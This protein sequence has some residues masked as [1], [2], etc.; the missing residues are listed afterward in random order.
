MLR[1]NADLAN[2]VE[3][4]KRVGLFVD[5]SKAEVTKVAEKCKEVHVPSGTTIVEQGTKGDR[6]FVLA[7][8]LAHVHVDGKKVASI[9]PGSFFGEMALIEHE[10]RSATVTAELPCRLLVVE[11]KDF[12]TVRSIPCVNDKVMKGMAGRLRAA[13]QSPS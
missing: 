8:G 7:E 3:L 2:K 9:G 5:C 4:L 10:V 11:E 1:G 13:N 6:F 12:A